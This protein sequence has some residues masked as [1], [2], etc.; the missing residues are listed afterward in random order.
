[1]VPQVIVYRMLVDYCGSISRFEQPAATGQIHT[2]S[3]AEGN[4]SLDIDT[5][6][7]VEEIR[8]WTSLESIGTLE[9]G[10]QATLLQVLTSLGVMLAHDDNVS[11][12]HVACAHH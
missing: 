4:G 3:L 5:R 11:L 9:E 2:D 1:M 10:L 7:S 12:S 6:A 8:A